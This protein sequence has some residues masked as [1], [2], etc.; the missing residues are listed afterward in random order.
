MDGNLSAEALPTPLAHAIPYGFARRYGVLARQGAGDAM[1]IVHRGMLSLPILLELQRVLGANLTLRPVDDVIFAQSL[2]HAYRDSSMA[3]AEV[4]GAAD[5]DSNLAALADSAAAT[6]DLLEQ[7]DDAPIIRLINALLQE[8]VKEHASDIHIETYERRLV[9]RF[10]VDGVLKDI[11]EPKRALAPLLVSRIKV[12]ARLDISEKRLP[13]DGRLS[14]RVA[15]REIDVRIATT[16]THWG[17][18]VVMRLLDKDAGR[19][20]LTVLGLSARD[21]AAIERIIRR[22]NG[23]VLVTGPTGSGKSTTLYA[24]LSGLNNGLRNIMTVEDPIEYAIEGIGQTQINPRIDLTFARSLRAIL[25]QDPNVVMVGEIRDRETAG[26]ALR[27]SL[28][29][30]LVLSTLH[31]NSAVG[32]VTRLI[33]M[34]VERFLLAPM[35]TGLIAQRLVRTL[36][37]ACRAAAE[38]TPLDHDLMFGAI[39]IGGP[40]FRPAGCPACNGQGYKGRTAIYEVVEVDEAFKALVHAGAAEAALEAQA[41]AQGLSLLQDGAQKVMGGITTVEEVARVSRES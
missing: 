22:P 26:E 12:M 35:L 29:G 1:E 18:R 39:E 23:I 24:M 37:P 34:G 13:Q 9:V 31:T 27:A 8:A 15:D 33:D 36:C 10:R 38:A 17:E 14:L 32:S 21:L 2:D 41:R 30:H 19:R 16:P 40:L 11:V 6:E 7:R 20:D 5:A 25:R 4:A 28:T 3:A